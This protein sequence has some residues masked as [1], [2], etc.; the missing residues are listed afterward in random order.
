MRPDK[1]PQRLRK[2]LGYGEV[3]LKDWKVLR[4]EV[5]AWLPY[6]VPI[7]P[8]ALFG[9][10]LLEVFGKFA[11]CYF[12]DGRLWLSKLA[13]E[14]LKNAGADGLFPVPAKIRA[15]R[16]LPDE[17]FE[18]QIEHSAQLHG[19]LDRTEIEA[20]LKRIAAQIDQ[21]HRA[22]AK[23]AARSPILKL[24]PQKKATLQIE[25]VWPNGTK[26]VRTQTGN[27]ARE[28]VLVC[29]KCGREDGKLPRRIVLVG[30]SIPDGVSLFRLAQRPN[31]IFCTERFADAAKKLGLTNILFEPVKT[32]GSEKQNGFA[33]VTPSRPELWFG[34][35][36]KTASAKKTSVAKQFP[37]GKRLPRPHSIATLLAAPALKSRRTELTALSQTCLRFGLETTKRIPIGASR[38]GGLPDLPKGVPWPGRAGAQLDF[39]LQ[40]NLEEAGKAVRNGV[41]PKRGWLWFFY[42]TEKGPWGTE[43]EDRKG[44]EIVFWDGRP[45]E[46]VPASVPGWLADDAVLPLRALSLQQTNWLPAANSPTI[47]KLKLT[48]PETTAYSGTISALRKPE[49][50]PI[51]KVLG[52]A[53]TIQED[54]AQTCSSIAGGRDWRLLLQLDSDPSVGLGFGDAGRLYFWIRESD[55]AARRFDRCWA[56]LQCH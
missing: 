47:K 22:A 33:K 46:L 30:S 16:K 8:C 9:P 51:H 45:D 35:Q 48:K 6:P 31:N 42:D 2:Q 26:E 41:L 5:I 21:L 56:I 4:K 3:N 49:D 13:V 40:L 18:L 37:K 7:A 44:W 53:D 34:K 50:C 29:D 39:L 23:R 52:W 12:G 43:G 38:F 19:S 28:R 20:D 17:Y 15:R 55:L 24:K 1:F 36:S 27:W 25:I 32:D 11:D 54:M 14:R 10:G